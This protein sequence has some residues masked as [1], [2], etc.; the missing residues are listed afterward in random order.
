MVELWWADYIQNE[1]VEGVAGKARRGQVGTPWGWSPRPRDDPADVP[2]VMEW[3]P[4]KFLRRTPA[5]GKETQ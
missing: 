3:S 4:E 5:S 1:G 2:T